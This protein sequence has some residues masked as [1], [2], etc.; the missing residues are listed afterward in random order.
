MKKFFILICVLLC[1]N[2]LHATF[3]LKDEVTFFNVGQGH[4]ALI[5]KISRVPLLID[6]GSDGRPYMQGETYE[7]E[8]YSEPLLIGQ[9]SSKILDCW[10]QSHNGELQ[11]GKY[12]LNIIV[13]HP[14][15]DHKD[16]IPSILSQLHSF[17]A[18]YNFTFSAKALLGGN[19]TLYPQEFLK[20]CSFKYSVECLGIYSRGNC[21]FLESS[22]CITHLF[23]PKGIQ[24]DDN[25]WSIIIRVQLDDISAVFTGDANKTV[26]KQMLDSLAGRRNELESD[27]LLAPHHGSDNDTYFDSWDQA[28]NPRAIIIGA[29]PHRR[30]GHPRGEII[31]KHLNLLQRNGRIWS[32][33]VTPHCILYRSNQAL[34]ETIQANFFQAKQRL[35]DEVPNVSL[36]HETALEKWHLVWI[37]APVFTLWTTGSLAF[38]GDPHKPLYLDAPNGLMTYVAVPE[39][40][41]F[42][43]PTQRDR[44]PALIEFVSEFSLNGEGDLDTVSTLKQHVKTFLSE[45]ETYLLKEGLVLKDG[46]TLYGNRAR[47][48][49]S[50][51]EIPASERNE[52][53]ALVKPL[54]Q[55]NKKNFSVRYRIFNVLKAIRSGERIPLITFLRDQSFLELTDAARTTNA[56]E[57]FSNI[58]LNEAR[59]I[60]QLLQQIYPGFIALSAREKDSIFAMVTTLHSIN[61]TRRA[62]VF[63]AARPLIMPYE[64]VPER[65]PKVCFHDVDDNSSLISLFKDEERLDEL[66]KKLQAAF[67]YLTNDQLLHLY[68]ENK[69]FFIQVLKEIPSTHRINFLTEILPL[70][71]I[72]SQKEHHE[73][74]TISVRTQQLA[75]IYSEPNFSL[76]IYYCRLQMQENRFLPVDD[77]KMLLSFSEGYAK[78]Q[79][80]KL[81]RN[82]T[83]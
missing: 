57:T 79:A 21:G 59:E 23:C 63:T 7:W 73:S 3:P 42:L 74:W 60:M 20:D 45:A 53:F 52:L 46:L 81:A 28:V 64:L 50:I 33:K 54:I 8:T 13:T 75:K 43:S 9:I 80:V 44:E 56:I 51:L 47:I 68:G 82:A 14:D 22:G 10:K 19:E 5:N 66:T 30:Y 65:D 6:A 49:N 38:R 11:R 61:P 39:V 55:S 16:F 18:Q 70:F 37:D 4:A 25:R 15:K 36:Q 32:Q 27:L 34:H 78:N 29:A 2:N 69:H 77:F 76:R 26:K 40:K 41:Y 12:Q 67:Q 35:F 31:F 58:P 1:S 72:I 24:S 62:S 83:S 71:L 17:Q 48:L